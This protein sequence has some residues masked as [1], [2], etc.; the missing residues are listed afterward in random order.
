MQKDK[1]KQNDSQS[2]DVTLEEFGQRLKEIRQQLRLLQKDFAASLEVTGSFLSEVEKGKA[3]PG[4]DVLKRI[5][6]VYNVN[7]NYLID[8]IGEPFVDRNQPAVPISS[9]T[10]LEKE[11]LQELLFYIENAPVVRYAVY[12]FF[13]NYLYKNKGMIE[14]DMEKIR[15]Y[16]NKKKQ[17]ENPEA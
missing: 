11:K 10:G 8:G 1:D 13:S 2:R 6:Y 14:E 17:E 9:A 5:Y 4:F 3:N 15:K 12:E 7:L 16:L